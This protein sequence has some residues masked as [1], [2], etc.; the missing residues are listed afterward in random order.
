MFLEALM[1]KHGFKPYR[2]EWWHFSDTQSYSVEQVFEPTE[3]SW[4]YADCNEFISLRTKP[5]TSAEVITRILV[6]EKFQVLAHHGDFSL[7]EYNGLL[8]YVLN[9]YIMSAE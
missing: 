1:A 7:I 4:Y 2:G 8:G 9:H 6:N 5:D 3:V